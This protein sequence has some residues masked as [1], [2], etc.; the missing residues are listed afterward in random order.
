MFRARLLYL[1]VGFAAGAGVGIVLAT[2]PR[3]GRAPRAH[4][5]P[6]ERPSVVGTTRGEV[7]AAREPG[8]DAPELAGASRSGG[9][10]DSDATGTLE[11]DCAGVRLHGGAVVEGRDIAGQRMQV[12]VPIGDDR[13]GRVE[14]VPGEYTVAW[15]DDHGWPSR[16]PVAVAPG[17]VTRVR[18]T[19]RRELLGSDLPP[20]M[21]AVEVSTTALDGA[22]FPGVSLHVVGRAM[23]GAQTMERRT[24]AD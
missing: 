7:P 1:V 12:G 20:G 19:E 11:I 6:M 5:L 15:S 24:G 4:D 18:L 23:S 16:L 3:P 13:V 21:A 2:N 9:P 22:P 17:A 10:A 8:A 14:L